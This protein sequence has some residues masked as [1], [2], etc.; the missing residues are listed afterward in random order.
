MI[1]NFEKNK[2]YF[3]N[4]K[5]NMIIGAAVMAV[6]IV[7]LFMRG[8]WDF[9]PNII[10]IP[11]TAIGAVIFFIDFMK[12]SR[13]SHLDEAIAKKRELITEQLYEKYDLY[14]R[15]LSYI[16]PVVTD[17]YLYTENSRVRR[18][19]NGKYRSDIYSMVKLFFVEGELVYLKR[20][21]SFLEE[22]DLIEDGVI[23]YKNIGK[24]YT[25]QL[26]SRYPLGKKVAEVKHYRFTIEDI[27]GNVIFTC[28]TTFDAAM[29]ACV[30]DIESLAKKAKGAA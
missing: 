17:Q 6:G 10:G 12:T 22:Y 26:E 3:E 16:N 4:N 28:P 18:D 1:L 19:G 9:N 27:E 5:K 13:D 8:S 20:Q 15:Q 11:L 2:R 7:F 21:F 24:V 30:E 14:E 29:D 23:E 25:E